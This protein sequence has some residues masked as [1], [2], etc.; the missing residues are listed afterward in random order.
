MTRS[1]R[2]LCKTNDFKEQ[3]EPY[4]IVER[5]EEPEVSGNQSGCNQHRFVWEEDS[6]AP[7]H[8][9]EAAEGGVCFSPLQIEEPREEPRCETPVSDNIR[10]EGPNNADVHLSQSRDVRQGTEV[11]PVVDIDMRKHNQ[12][13]VGRGSNQ[14]RKSFT[15]REHR[16]IHTVRNQRY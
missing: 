6:C 2:S 1:S 10:R 12:I 7:L 11:R 15:E 13:M 8:D 9:T 5:G 14:R 4:R 16:S 3:S